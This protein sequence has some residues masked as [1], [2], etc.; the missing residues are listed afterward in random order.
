[1]VAACLRR[2]AVVHP[3]DVFA[4]VWLWW[5]IAYLDTWEHHY[6]MLLPLVAL[7]GATGRLSGWTLWIPAALWGMPS[8]WSV[9]GPAVAAGEPGAPGLVI[10]YFLQRPVGVFWVFGVIARRALR[11]RV[12][13]T[14]EPES[15]PH[16]WMTRWR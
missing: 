7:L 6:V 15:H 11:R 16:G 3:L 5:F 8:L 9:A 4:L 12:E 14:M 1:V 2:K 10:L 13:E